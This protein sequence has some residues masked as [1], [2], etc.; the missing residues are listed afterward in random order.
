M[1]ALIVKWRLK[2]TPA[3]ALHFRPQ[4]SDVE[5]V[6]DACNSLINDK[7]DIMSDEV[8]DPK[9]LA[10]D[11]N[12][13]LFCHQTADQRELLKKCGDQMCFM[14]AT[15]LSHYNICPAFI[16]FVCADKCEIPSGWF[17]CNTI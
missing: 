8:P 7:D 9:P 5:G 4:S 6:N 2:K 10:S 15:S 12:S 16:I 17:L 11:K 1:D 3:D 13:L 14:D